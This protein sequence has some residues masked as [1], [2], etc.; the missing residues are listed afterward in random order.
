MPIYSFLTSSYA[1]DIYL[2]GNRRFTDRD[3]KT[4][5]PLAYHQPVKQY[6]AD[7]YYIDQIENALAQT[8]LLQQEYDD[9][10]ALKG[11]EDPQ[12]SSRPAESI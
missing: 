12:Y 4:G 2:Y 5:I 8:W 9:T 10:I 1:R 7:T 3:G 11:P 6:A